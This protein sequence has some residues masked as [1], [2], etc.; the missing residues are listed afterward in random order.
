MPTL[1]R[2]KYFLVQHHYASGYVCV[3]RSEAVFESIS[4]VVAELNACRSALVGIDV[5]QHGVLF[6]WRRSPFSTDPALHKALVE[7]VDSFG[8]PFAR[9]A[10]LFATSVGTMQAARVGRAMGNRQMVVFDD[11]SAAIEYVIYP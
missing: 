5:A 10:I 4:D 9:R 6:D 8:E 11:E 2:S 7:R 3:V 1:Y